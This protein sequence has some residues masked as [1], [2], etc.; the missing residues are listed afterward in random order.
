MSGRGCSTDGEELRSPHTHTPPTLSSSPAHQVILSVSGPRRQT[1][2]RSSRSVHHWVGKPPI[3][4]LPSQKSNATD[5][6]RG[7]C[8]R[9]RERVCCV[10]VRAV[11]TCV[12]MGGGLLWGGF[13]T[14]QTV[15]HCTQS[16]RRWCKS[17]KV[18][19]LGHRSFQL[20]LFWWLVTSRE[21]VLTRISPKYIDFISL[22]AGGID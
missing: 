9:W 5:M 8:G 16:Q 17:E 6:K 19:C 21:G 14:R 2:F 11:R 18:S 22:M 12:D 1:P 15:P 3:S 13:N 20:N 7:D 4:L 10:C